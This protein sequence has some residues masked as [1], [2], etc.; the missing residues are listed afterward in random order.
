MAWVFEGN[1]YPAGTEW[2]ATCL[3]LPDLIKLRREG[4]S[5]SSIAHACGYHHGAGYATAPREK[6]AADSARITRIVGIRAQYNGH[7][8]R[9]YVAKTVVGYD[10]AVKL[11]RGLG[12]DYHDVG[13]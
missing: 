4:H 10:T 13:V 8:R 5:W 11:A 1:I 9:K 6:Y 2:Y 3:F 12:I 7:G